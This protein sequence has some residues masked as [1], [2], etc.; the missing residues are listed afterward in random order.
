MLSLGWYPT[1]DSWDEPA[2]RWTQSR[3]SPCRWHRPY[4]REAARR[5]KG[6]DTIGSWEAEESFGFM[7]PAG[8]S[9]QVSWG[10]MAL[11]NRPGFRKK[12][13]YNWNV[14]GRDRDICDYSWVLNRPFLSIDQ[15]LEN[16]PARVSMINTWI[17]LNVLCHIRHWLFRP[18]KVNMSPSSSRLLQQPVEIW[19][20][21][22]IGWKKYFAGTHLFPSQVPWW[23][24]SNPS[25]VTFFAPVF[26]LKNGGQPL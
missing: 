16:D 3:S 5:P 19:N 26:F 13:T 10:S 23:S 17:I 14:Y 2:N 4:W 9:W 18:K 24:S 11:Q 22:S 8:S 25:L 21:D 6:N 15:H 20:S 7:A 1:Y 12:F